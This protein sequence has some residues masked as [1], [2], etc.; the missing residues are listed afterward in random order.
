VESN[1]AHSENN[2]EPPIECVVFKL[3]QNSAFHI[4]MGTVFFTPNNTQMSKYIQSVVLF[5]NIFLTVLNRV[6]KH[7]LVAKK[8][9][10]KVACRTMEE[11]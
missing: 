6:P 7:R 11:A 2:E 5:D 4:T 1:S 10:K 8:N 3:H 9:G